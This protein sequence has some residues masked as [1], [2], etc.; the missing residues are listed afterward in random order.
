[1][2]I[3]GSNSP[4]LIKFNKNIE[5]ITDISVL[6]IFSDNSKKRW[7]KENIILRE[8]M[9]IIEL[10]QQETIEFPPGNIYIE[11]KWCDDSLIYMAKIV[12][13]YVEERDDKTILDLGGE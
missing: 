9:A 3:Q 13:D 7:E 1:M 4:I 11:I 10:T 8:N 2:I 12:K 6:I 5:N